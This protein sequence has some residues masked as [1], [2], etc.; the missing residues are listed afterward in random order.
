M[1]VSLL[2]SLF[3][4]LAA[5]VSLPTLA[6]EEDFLAARKAYQAGDFERF[7]QHARKLPED[8]LL[9]PYLVF[10]RLKA[11]NADRQ[12]RIR[13]IKQYPDSVLAETVRAELA[14]EAAQRGDWSAYAAWSAQLARKDRELQCYDLQARL[15]RGKT[16]AR[17]QTLPLYLTARDD[18][19]G[20]EGLFTRLFKLGVLTA[21]DRYARFRLALEADNLR[22]VRELNAALPKGERLAAGSLTRALRAPDK[23]VAAKPKNR[24]Q[25]ELALYALTRLAKTDL[26][27]AFRLWEAHQKKHSTARRRYGWGQLALYAALRHDDRALAWFKRA[28]RTL[29]ETQL[30]WYARASLRAGRWA[31]LKRVIEAMPPGMQKQAVWRYWLGRA[32][33][34]LGARYQANQIFVQLSRAHHYYGLLAQE[35]LPV[36]LEARPANSRVR[37]TEVNRVK[38]M[39][40]I[41]RALL[42]HRI[43]LTTHAVAEWNWALRGRDD[44]ILL[45]AAEIARRHQ[46][47]DQAINT[48]ERTRKLHNFDLR[49]LTPYRD[50]AHA[51][52]R[53][54]GLDEAW[55]YG[56]MRQESRFIAH[57]RSRAGAQGLMQIMPATA[58]WIARQLGEKQGK[59][60]VSHPET[61][62]RY[63]S[64]YLKRMLDDLQGSMVLA[65][66]AYN[67]GP[68]RARRWQAATPL[69]GAIYIE[70][71]PLQETREYVKKV[72][73]NAMHYSQRLGMKRTALKDR[74]GIVPARPG[75]ASSHR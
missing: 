34:A 67:A 11:S 46:W 3:C 70:T 7:E 42:L 1:S 56:L 41:Q 66:A 24:A 18:P 57:A 49:Y 10:W 54:F 27:A 58:A 31:E 5:L 52:A 39:P 69:E 40:G 23:L 21:K 36:R 33:K 50:L 55:I 30:A 45:A 44:V 37:E 28:G 60:D 61:N 9:K 2:A 26:E 4:L 64:F 68:N 20:C 14:R 71:I 63:G 32:Y 65:T 38:A 51:Q 13:F 43:G 48:A 74:L 25:A 6:W 47:Y 35:E 22:L 72:M 16:P 62:V 75:A 19:P 8:H 29:T 15:G 12:A 17:A 59:V 73:A 53:K